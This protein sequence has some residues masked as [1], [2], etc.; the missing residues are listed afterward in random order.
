MLL[1]QIRKFKRLVTDIRWSS[2]TVSA[3]VSN[4]A[5]HAASSAA[6]NITRDEV[7]SVAGDSV[8]PTTSQGTVSFVDAKTLLKR[9]DDDVDLSNFIVP[10]P[11][12]GYELI[13]TDPLS[14]LDFDLY[15]FSPRGKS[16]SEFLKEI[17]NRFRSN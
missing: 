12:K 17:K 1:L 15:L 9:P 6:A 13:K 14:Y 2:T 8:A 3:T 10:E 4:T 7:A 11:P 16:F 5:P